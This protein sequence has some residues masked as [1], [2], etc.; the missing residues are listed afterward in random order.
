[1]ILGIGN[2]IIEVARIKTII[3]RHPKRFLDKVFTLNE[4]E[5]CL[6]KKDPSLHLAG[7]FASKEAIV[8]SLGT[9]FSQGLSWL[10]IEILNDAK[11]KPIVFLSPF[12][13]QLFN[14]P[15]LHISLSHCHQYA[16]AFAIWTR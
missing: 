12:A 16:T 11:G 5:Y 8:K 7:R 2:D 6:K 1:M 15:S 9:G 10:D 3:A 14:F 4:Q 13:N